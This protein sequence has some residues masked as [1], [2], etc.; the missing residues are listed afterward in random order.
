MNNTN[1]LTS[2]KALRRIAIAY[3]TEQ[4][5]QCL[6]DEISEQT[7]N[8]NLQGDSV[9]IINAL[10]RAGVIRELIDNGLSLPEATRELARRMRYLV[11][12]KI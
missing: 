4:I 5:N 6:N 2:V 8:C 12:L 7:N 1:Q 10:S 9:E 11:K 3:T